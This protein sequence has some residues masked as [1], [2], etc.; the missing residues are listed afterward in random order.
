MSF[1]SLVLSSKATVQYLL[2]DTG[3][4]PPD[5]ISALSGFLLDAAVLEFAGLKWGRRRS[6]CVICSSI[7]IATPLYFSSNS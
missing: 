5:H 4:R 2:C 7:T 3:T 6:A 1:C